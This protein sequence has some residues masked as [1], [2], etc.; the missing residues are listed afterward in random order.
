MVGSI[1]ECFLGACVC[2]ERASYVQVY[3]LIGH[4]EFVYYLGLVEY[5]AINN[6]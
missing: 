3:R 2:E 6:I 5:A 1:Q 4:Y